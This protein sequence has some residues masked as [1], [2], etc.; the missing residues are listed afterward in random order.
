MALRTTAVATAA[1]VFLTTPGFVGCKPSNG[2]TRGSTTGSGVASDGTLDATGHP[3]A[4]GG[5]TDDSGGGDGDAPV[6]DG[7][8]GSTVDADVMPPIYLSQQH[9]EACLVGQGDPFPN[10]E[11]ADLDGVTQPIHSRF[12]E[13]LTVVCIWN[14]DNPIAQW[15]L[16]D[17]NPEVVEQYGDQGVN[18]VTIGYKVPAERARAI[19]DELSGSLPVLLDL[20][21][22]AFA[23]VATQY[24][25][26]TYL[27]GEDGSILWFDLDYTAETR[28]HLDRAIR[29]ALNNP[30]GK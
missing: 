16:N 3:A 26:R 27:L 17:L 30:P 28:R 7:A 13:R 14:D 8:Q 4:V 1:F 18:V 12:G 19:V 21:G 5:D 22:S 11:L 25:P 20:D 10:F 6:T 2:S 29:V 9:Q 23:Q 15:Q 24:L